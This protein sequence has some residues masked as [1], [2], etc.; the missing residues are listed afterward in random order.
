MFH[1]E[2]KVVEIILF[3]KCDELILFAIVSEYI[4]EKHY[5]TLISV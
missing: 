3:L 2:Y 1:I 5:P 4:S